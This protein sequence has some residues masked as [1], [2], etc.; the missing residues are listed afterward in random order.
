[1]GVL[2]SITGAKAAKAAASRAF[3]DFLKFR[4]EIFG[5]QGGFLDQLQG[6]R[7]DPTLRKAEQ[8]IFQKSQGVIDELQ[9]NLIG[10]ALGSTSG[11]QV[12][13]LESARAAAGGR[14]G[15]AFGGGAGRVAAAGARAVAPQQAGLLGQAL[16]QA[17]QSRL[18]NF[19]AQGQFAFNKR[20][21]ELALRQQF[22][23]GQFGLA[24]GAQQQIQAAT[25]A[26][27]Q[28]KSAG[29]MGGLGLTGK[30]FGKG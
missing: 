9:R 4:N 21:G 3:P 17:S 2:D 14:G 25:S 29:L 20:A 8:G 23:Q 12:A 1:M 15:L 22:L 5:G 7:S 18:Q 10:G 28:A 11:G 13:A 30:L 27:V 24:G 6:L 16:S 19:Q 26:E